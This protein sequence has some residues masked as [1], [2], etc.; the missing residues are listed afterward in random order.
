M[1]TTVEMQSEHRNLPILNLTESPA[2]SRRTFDEACLTHLTASEVGAASSSPC[3]Q[4]LWQFC[5]ASILASTNDLWIAVG[6]D[7]KSS[8]RLNL[9]NQPRFVEIWPLLQ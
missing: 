8:W 3:G 9:E 1:T 2:N 4:F 7:F 5:Q 6:A